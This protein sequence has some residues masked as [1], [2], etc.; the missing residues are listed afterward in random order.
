MPLF[1]LLPFAGSI[2]IFVISFVIGFFAVRTIN[3]I[4]QDSHAKEKAFLIE[5]TGKYAPVPVKDKL[6]LT[7]A[8][9]TAWEQITTSL[10]L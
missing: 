6:K 8:E 4:K 1:F 3:K 10:K 5:S 7:E 9:Q 2:T